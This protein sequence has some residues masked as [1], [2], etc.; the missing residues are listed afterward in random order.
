M[1][2]TA[3]AKFDFNRLTLGEIALIE[4]LSGYGIGALDEGKPQGKFLAALYTVARRRNGDPTYT[5]NKAL[6]VEILEAQAYLGLDDTDDAAAADDL[7][8]AVGELPETPSEL[9]ESASGLS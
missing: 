6:G 4:D 8:S 3:P 9:H 2:T 1:D 7:G 5:F